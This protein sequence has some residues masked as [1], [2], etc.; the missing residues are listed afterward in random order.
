MRKVIYFEMYMMVIHITD[1]TALLSI[2]RWLTIHMQVLA[3]EQWNKVLL[4]LQTRGP[5]Q[6]RIGKIKS[7]LCVTPINNDRQTHLAS[8]NRSS[9]LRKTFANPM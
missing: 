4:D 3:S 9:N 2:P 8:S 7:Q 6:A 1:I 5:G